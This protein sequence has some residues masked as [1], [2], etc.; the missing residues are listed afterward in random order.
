MVGKMCTSR[1]RHALTISNRDPD[2]PAAAQAHAQVGTGYPR[3]QFRLSCPW[4]PHTLHF[5]ALGETSHD[6]LSCPLSPHQEQVR[7]PVALIAVL[8]VIRGRQPS[9]VGFKMREPGRQ[10]IA[11]A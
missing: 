9:R 3:G 11:A 6:R 8:R 4:K 5:P 7:V 1:L 2:M 10:T